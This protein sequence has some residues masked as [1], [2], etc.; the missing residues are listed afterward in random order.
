MAEKHYRCL[1]I[2][3]FNLDNFSGY[4]GNDLSDPQV[5]VHVAPYGQ[6]FQTLMDHDQDCW[7]TQP[8]Y[9]I[10][11]TQA[12]S[13]F[14]SFRDLVQFK[15]V[16]IER[17][18]DE[19]DAYAALIKPLADKV[20][21]VFIPTWV[22]PGHDA[23]MG[24]LD[25]KNGIGIA[26]TLMR[27]NLRLSEQ[28]EPVFN[29]YLLNAQRWVESAGKQAFNDKLWYMAKVPFGNK[30]FQEAVK[31]VKSA[32]RGLNGQAKK[33]LVLDL[34][35][36]LWG[37]VVGDIGWEN[38]ILGG[39]DPVGEALVDFQKKLKSL[40]NRGVL[41]GIVSKNEEATALEAIQSHPEMVLALEDFAGWKINWTDK[42]KNIVDLVSE[43][44]LGLQSV[45]FIDDNPVERARVR[46][47]L[48]EVE[49]PEWPEDM[50]LYPRELL[51]LT[52]FNTPAVSEED[53]KRTQMYVSEKKRSTLKQ[54]VH[55][56]DEWLKTLDIRV[57]V[58][59]LNE[60]NLT[61]TNQLL[62]KTNQ[63]NLS[64][65]R[66]TEQE[67]VNWAKESHHQIWTFRVLDKFGDS[68]LTGLISLEIRNKKAR[69][70]DF[71]L[72]CRVMGRKIEETMLATAI[73]FLAS[74]DIGEVTA[75]YLPTPKNK[76][77]LDFWKRSGFS[78]NGAVDTFHW[79]VNKPYPYPE[80]VAVEQ[81]ENEI[82]KI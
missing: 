36:T 33:L 11:W 38:L 37:G 72:S 2:S 1:A 29:V 68:G 20:S 70:I 34:D 57:Q 67:F 19:V 3:D 31:D 80:Q 64:T 47:A 23:G 39:H 59:E 7:K 66:M 10:L 55:S 8:D 24:M 16:E 52:C 4:M 27:M 63:M 56:L 74:R 17:I 77:C 12:V 73:N 9:V 69:I 46:E 78:L 79:E 76:P 6:V 21:A 25:L 18:L 65:R 82:E 14:E 15:K 42:A 32:L 22:Q 51:S 71:V 28:L 5:S 75:R 30:V 13:L 44:N 35:N 45:V 26:N 53:L 41:L 43:L 60:S 40:T 62:N 81:E 50:L 48:P 58:S 61:R 54:S 49:V